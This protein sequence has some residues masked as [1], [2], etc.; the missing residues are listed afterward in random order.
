[1]NHKRLMTLILVSA[2]GTST[3]ACISGGEP[4][5]PSLAG[6]WFRQ[7]GD[8]WLVREYSDGSD[9]SIPPMREWAYPVGGEPILYRS[10]A[11]V[12]I[13]D[14]TVVPGDVEPSDDVLNIY[15]P[16]GTVYEPIVAS[17]DKEFVVRDIYYG[18]EVTWTATDFF[19]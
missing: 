7:S 14:E 15:Y 8:L 12:I 19:P 6:I 10:A 3:L 16:G 2:I 9:E 13:S 18:G 5:N 11:A 4:E 1:M 17:S